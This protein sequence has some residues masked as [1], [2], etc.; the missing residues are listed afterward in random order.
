M[1][2]T[3]GPRNKNAISF[4]IRNYSA[5]IA[6]T[7]KDTEAGKAIADFE[8]FLTTGTPKFGRYSGVD[9]KSN[10]EAVAEDMI[11]KFEDVVA[12]KLIERLHK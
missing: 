2:V 8:S 7:I 10:S 3:L 4:V 12:V 5:A 11:I 6:L 1:E 9:I